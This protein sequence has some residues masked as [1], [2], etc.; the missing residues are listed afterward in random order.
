MTHQ[1]GPGCVFWG[2]LVMKLLFFDV[3]K[4]SGRLDMRL[5]LGQSAT[6]VPSAGARVLPCEGH[7]SPCKF[8]F[9]NHPP[10][11][12]LTTKQGFFFFWTSAKLVTVTD[13]ETA[14]CAEKC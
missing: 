7:L 1:E 5:S 9:G 8:P 4:W 6:D 13:G 2:A 12:G 14:V 10:E 11:K 3:R